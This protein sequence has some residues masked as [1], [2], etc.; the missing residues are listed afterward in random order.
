MPDWLGTPPMV[1]I[2]GTVGPGVTFDGI[3]TSICVNP[4]TCPGAAPL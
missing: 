3:T 2:I 4:S 1:T